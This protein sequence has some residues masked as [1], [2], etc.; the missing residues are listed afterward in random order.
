MSDFLTHLQHYIESHALFKANDRVLLAV[1]GGVDSVVMAQGLQQLG[2]N[3]GIAHC[4]FK[5]RG[6][7]SNADEEFVRQL[8]L[9]FQVPFFVKQF[10]TS[11]LAQETKV[12]IQMAARDLR[13][14]WLEDIRLQHGFSCVATAHHQNDLVETVLLNLVRGTGLAGFHGILPRQ[15]HLVR[16]LLFATREQ[17][18]DFAKDHI[19][20]WREDSSNA[21]NK[22]ARNLLRNNVVPLLKTLNPSLESTMQSTAEKVALA[23]KVLAQHVEEAKINWVTEAQGFVK[24][25]I[26][27]LQSMPNAMYFLYAIL[28]EFGFAWSVSKKVMESGNSISGKIFYSSTHRLLKDRENWIIDHKEVAK[29]VLVFILPTTQTVRLP[30]GKVLNLKLLEGGLELLPT[31]KSK[32]AVM[33]DYDKLVFPLTLR[34]WQE[35]DSFVPFGMEGEKKVSDFL[36]DAKY[37]L[38][39][40]ERVLILQ[41]E[42]DIAAVIGS[43]SGQRYAIGSGTQKILVAELAVVG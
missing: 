38:F 25:D 28:Q 40:K 42:Q 33:L 43:R 12:S 1:S 4:N 14:A 17:V 2:Y 18:E 7:E 27:G 20:R 11:Q 8:A 32:S 23:E 24:I 39:E 22:Y 10:E 29:F 31:L 26:K 15:G 3:F 21:S 35:G 19:L 16:P 13:Y 9:S 34:S 36:I 41:S 5:L 30:F 6:E 37:N